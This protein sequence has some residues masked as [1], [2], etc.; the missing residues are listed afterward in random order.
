MDILFSK[1]YYGRI[2]IRNSIVS[3]PVVFKYNL[4]EIEVM[5]A[6]VDYLYTTYRTFSFYFQLFT[7]L[8]LFIIIRGKSNN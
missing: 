8:K 7:Y 4:S 3:S 2:G 6:N 5:K 1:I